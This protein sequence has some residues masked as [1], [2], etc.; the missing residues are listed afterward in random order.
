MGHRR[1]V[2]AVLLAATVTACGGGGG[3]EGKYYNSK[4]GEFAMELKAGKAINVQG[5]E[6]VTLSYEVK[7]DS[8]V[9]RD[10]SGGPADVMTL[11][12]ESDGSLSFGPL[13]S[14]TKR[15]P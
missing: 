9:L 4:S 3:I 1:H 13:G 12:I 11:G 10:P 6:G 14:L 15:R 2:A 7:G 8:L 5:L